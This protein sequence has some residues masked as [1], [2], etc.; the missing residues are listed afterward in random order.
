MQVQILPRSTLLV[1]EVSVSRR[2]TLAKQR[3][4]YADMFSSPIQFSPDKPCA[5]GQERKQMTEQ[6]HTVCEPTLKQRI[7]DEINKVSRENK[8]NTPD[9][10]LA[11]Y[12]INCLNAYEQASIAREKWYGKS[13]HI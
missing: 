1:M 9:W 2:I 13:L 7:S 11:E 8:S 4:T 10:I 6:N 3:S 5:E 12:L